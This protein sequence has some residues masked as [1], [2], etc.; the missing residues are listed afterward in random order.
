[1]HLI[2]TKQKQQTVLNVGK[3]FM[4]GITHSAGNSEEVW[5]EWTDQPVAAAVQV[6]AQDRRTFHT[7][8]RRHVALKE[9]FL[10][11]TID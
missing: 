3:H 5:C 4:D 9:I 1:M 2:E 11:L 10:L 6:P 7:G 8:N